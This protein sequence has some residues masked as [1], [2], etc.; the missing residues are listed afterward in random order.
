MK[1]QKLFC[2]ECG[3]HFNAMGAE[4]GAYCPRCGGYEVYN[5]TPEGAA[6]SIR[7]LNR[8]EADLIRVY[9]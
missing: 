7:E 6:E 3:N 5:D 8:Y 4:W 9:C 2:G 1:I